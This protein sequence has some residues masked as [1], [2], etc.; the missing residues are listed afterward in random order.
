[1]IDTQLDNADLTDAKLWEAQRSGWSIKGI[2]CDRVFWDRDGKEPT[3]YEDGAFER[4]FAENPRIVLHYAGG[5]SPVDFAMLPLIVERLQTDHPNSSLHIRSVQDDGSGATVT[6]TVEDLTDR[7]DQ[8]FAED[9]ETMRADLTS[10]QHR[11]QQEERL[12]LDAEAGYRAMVQDVLPKLLER[13]LP[14]TNVH[15]GQITGPTTIEGSSMSNDTYNIHG[16]V[17]AVGKNAHAHDMTFQ[18]AWNQSN[19]DLLQLAEELTRLRAAMK[20]E[21]QG[22]REQDK[23]IVAVADAEEAA[24]KGDGPTV[25]Q[26]LKTAGTW[27]FGVAEKIGVSVAAE[28]IKRAM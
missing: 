9:V 13:A 28:A 17:G 26:Y 19:I 1:L 14:Q 18:Q 5:M 21:T 24:V 8:V 23:A 3:E 11:L 2:V 22:T 25:L 6:I 20:Q 4:I 10:L 27:A 16:Q 7:S 15:V 12:R